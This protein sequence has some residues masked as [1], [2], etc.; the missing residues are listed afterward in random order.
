[1]SICSTKGPPSFG[2]IQGTLTD[3][4]GSS[5]GDLLIKIPCFVQKK[6]NQDLKVIDLEWLVRGGELY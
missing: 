5:T 6:K 3:R 4:E 2:G 1:M